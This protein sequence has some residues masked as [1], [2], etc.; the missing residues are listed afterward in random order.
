MLAITVQ[1]EDS[2]RC[3]PVAASDLAALVRRIGDRGDTFLVVERIPDLPDIYIQVLH[4]AGEGY[5]LEHRDG[6]PDRHFQARIEGPES[7]IAAMTGWARLNDDWDAGI[8]W[9]L[10][11]LGPVLAPVPALDLE[12]GERELL[13]ARI[14]EVIAGG[15]ATRAELAELAEEYLVSPDRRP[16]SPAQARLL[17][18]RL[19]LERVEEQALWAGETD[20]ERVTLAFTALEAAGITARE[21]FTCCRTCGQTEIGAQAAPGARGFVYFHHQ[22]T[23]AVA[24]GQGRALLYGG[25]DGSAETTAAI[26]REVVAAIEAT[27]LTVEWD[28]NPQR[29]IT[30]TPLDWQRRLTG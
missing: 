8:A 23:D 24:A 18:D 28:G 6:A 5:I 16:V 11:D 20:P 15:Y 30:V 14:R 1:R 12:D 21:N 9:E 19:W 25:F 26:G 29:A 10:L 22:C 4:R 2:Q 27:G 17:A 7:V 13:E 3:H